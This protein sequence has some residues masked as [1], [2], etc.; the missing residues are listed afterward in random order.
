MLNDANALSYSRAFA[1]KRAYAAYVRDNL[2]LGPDEVDLSRFDV[3][4]MGLSDPVV[5]NPTTP[6]Q[7]SENM[8][9]E[10]VIIAAESE[11]P[12]EIGADD[13]K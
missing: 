5:K 4:G 3:K 10:M 11:I 7:R 1:V 13:L 9:G 6:D 8:R 12:A 2:H